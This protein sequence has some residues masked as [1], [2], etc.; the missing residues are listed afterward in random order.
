MNAE[1]DFEAQKRV[2]YARGRK[3]GSYIRDIEESIA[4]ADWPQ[5]EK[6][7]GKLRRYHDQVC[8]ARREIGA[9]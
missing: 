4:A 5:V 9:D 8:A 7:I 3:Y 6:D 2:E 1:V